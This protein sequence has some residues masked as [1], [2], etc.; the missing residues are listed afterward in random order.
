MDHSGVFFS[1]QEVYVIDYTLAQMLAGQ[2]GLPMDAVIKGLCMYA[3]IGVTTEQW[4]RY[5]KR[6]LGEGHSILQIMQAWT[7][8]G[9]PLSPPRPFPDPSTFVFGKDWSRQ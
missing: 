8:A 1:L 3:H 9:E 6:Q 7:E 2:Y 5:V 4:S